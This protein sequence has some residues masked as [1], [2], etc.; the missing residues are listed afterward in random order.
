MKCQI[1]T[2]VE[3]TGCGCGFEEWSKV[4]KQLCKCGNPVIASVGTNYVCIEHLPD[5]LIRC[6]SGAY[7][8]PKTGKKSLAP[9]SYEFKEDF[10][11][12]CRKE[13]ELRNTAP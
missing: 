11:K 7:L 9:V 12:A 10:L 2:K 1:L 6:G 4:E 13:S 8:G 3:A 5:A